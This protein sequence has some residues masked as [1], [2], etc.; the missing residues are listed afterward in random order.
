[1]RRLSPTIAF[2]FAA[3]LMSS[4]CATASDGDK[5][6]SAPA[7]DKQTSAIDLKTLPANLD[8]A[9]RH[10]QDLRA[11][12]K[13]AEATQSLAQLMLIA[14]DDARVVGEYGKALVEQGNGEDGAAFLN[15]AIEINPS[16]WTY[17]SA[18][19]VAYDEMGKPKDAKLA[20]Q[21]ALLMRPGDASVMNNLALS[22][23][24]SGDY[25]GA[26]AMIMQAKAADTADEK[27]DR[28]VALVESKMPPAAHARAVTT[29]SP[30]ARQTVTVPVAASPV[31]KQPTVT[32]S[33]APANATRASTAPTPT[34]HQAPTAATPASTAP[35]PSAHQA[36]TTATPATASAAGA[37]RVLGKDVVM[38]TVPSDP[39]AGPTASAKKAKHARPAQTKP[40]VADA[41]KAKTPALRMSADAS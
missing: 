32:A 3:A 7:A 30:V 17:F 36:P 40:A 39:L 2:A 38:Q 28:N 5:P 16:E 31:S 15:R 29:P 25:A 22:R 21:H 35:T 8:D 19:G 6:A 11:Q 4:A 14:P 12:G 9:I 18:L 37:P 34:A 23:M 10:A 20:Y 24:L 41:D 27:I 1:M 33:I 13:L 26:H